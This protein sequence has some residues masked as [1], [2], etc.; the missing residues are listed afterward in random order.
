MVLSHGAECG[1]FFDMKHVA[2]IVYTVVVAT[3]HMG[4]MALTP[5]T[6]YGH[7]Q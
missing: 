4:S 2:M 7:T 5:S 1:L 6:S 3:A